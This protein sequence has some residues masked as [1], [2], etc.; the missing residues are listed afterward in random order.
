MSRWLQPR[1]QIGL[2]GRSQQAK[3]A[4]WSCPVWPFQTPRHCH[5][6]LGELGHVIYALPPAQL[7]RAARIHV[8]AR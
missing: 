8:F 4:R 1:R 3:M 6:P 5:K 2:I 7:G